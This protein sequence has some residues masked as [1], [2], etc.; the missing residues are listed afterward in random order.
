M[1]KNLVIVESPAKAKTIEGFLGKD[2]TVR[3]SFGHVRDLVKKGYG[4]DVENNFTPTYEVQPDKE[5]VIAELRKLSKGADMV[6]LASDEDREGEAIS[7]HLYETLGLEK[8]KTKRIVFHEITKGAIEKAIQNPR[9]IDINLVNAQ[10]ARR[11]LDR[12]VGFELSPI[13]W[14]KIRP[15]LSAGR[16]QSVAVRLIVEREREIQNFKST[17]AFKVSALFIVGKGILKAE[18]DNRFKTEEEANA[19]L[20]K[21]KNAIYTINSVE[22]K[23]AKRSPSAPFTTSTLQQEASRKLGFSVSQTMVVAQRLYESG[24]IT[25]MRTDSVN[26]SET[27][28]SQAR[29][30]ITKNYGD[31]YHHPRQ[32]KTKSKGA[33]E[34]HEAIRPTYI[35]TS[36]I[37]GERNEQRLYELI[38]KRTIA[39]Q[40]ADAE[41]EKTT[42]KIGINTTG[43]Q[44][45]AQGE[46]LKF[47]GFLK[48]Y[49]EGTDDEDDEEKSSMLPPMSQGDKLQVK[50]I[51]A[52]Q[53]FTYHPARYTEASL[54]KKLE[55]LGIGRPSTYA[56]TISTV[57]KRNYVEKTDREGTLRN[58]TLLTFEGN[59]ITT[60]TKTETTGAEKSKLFPTDIGMV[61][62][63]FLIQYFPNIMDFNFTARVE[64]EF[65]EIAE[66]KM[67]WTDMLEEF[68]TPFHKVVENTIDNSERAS[69]ERAL[70]KDPKSG[71][72]VIVRIGRFGPLAQIG[73]TNEET[74]EKATFASL[75]KEQSIETITLEDALD[76]FKL[77]M[78]LGTY[79]DKEVIVSVGRFGPYVKFGEEF[80]SIPRSEDPLKVDMDR[81]I[82]LI[83]EKEIANAP[84]AFYEGKPVTKGK[85]RFGP[86]I[87]YE[88]LYINVPRAYNFDALSQKDIDELVSK[89]LEK[90]SNRFIQK[91]DDEKIAIE[92][93]RWGAFIRFGKQMLKLIND[94]GGKFAPEELTSLSLE[95][96]KKMIVAQDPKAFD[97]KGKKS[98]AKSAGA[99]GGGAKKKAPAKTGV[100][101]KIIKATVKKVAVKKAASKKASPK[102]AAKKAAKKK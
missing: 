77:P 97:K 16:V 27:A 57:Q 46:V 42:A 31:K 44:F 65:D 25:Y 70:G 14:R 84:V 60:Q 52:T 85:G 37:A 39:S 58:Y 82:E 74:G 12:L 45:V 35:E 18:L 83:G 40:M 15:S 36:E 8:K 86:F 91:W 93:G 4:I 54:V 24:K 68:Y 10:Q 59:T 95:D 62:N 7:W 90:E 78:T 56:P 98:A 13:L 92:N 79:K 67:K 53:R 21:C 75:R 19:F 3:S 87:K 88:S 50:E 33:Q 34:A 100:V 71:K 72:P 81:A 101:K 17:S 63:D 22:T 26:L 11:I 47:D 6:W 2:F 102:K 61:V 41:L 89:K 49:I 51:S 43:E 29:V 73:E 28:M 48:V 38:W 9:E 80:I 23:P 20:E 64:E 32:F 66:G 96:V 99:V 1:S 30:A 94:K 55:E 5:R 76:L 69:G